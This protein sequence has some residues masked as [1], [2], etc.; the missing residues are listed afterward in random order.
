MNEHLEKPVSILVGVQG[1]VLVNCLS[2]SQNA[3]TT[4]MQQDIFMTID[5]VRV[6]KSMLVLWTLHVVSFPSI[7]R[8]ECL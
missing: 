3:N 6:I 4:R 5:F 7:V 2:V 1:L 8:L